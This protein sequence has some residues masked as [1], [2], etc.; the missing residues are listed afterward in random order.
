MESKQKA[1]N[2][3]DIRDP[4]DRRPRATV[5]I[6]DDEDAVRESTAAILRHVGLDVRE[7][8]D[9][10]AATWILASESI[11]VLLLDLHL[12]HQ[13]GTDVLEALEESSEVVIFSAFGDVEES[14]IRRHFG[15]AVFEFL[16]KP[17]PPDRLVEV[18]EAAVDHA[19]ADG[20]EPRV[21]PIA[22]RMALRLAMAGLSRISPDSEITSS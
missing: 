7:A 22:P 10:A 8:A 12:R 9:G 5:L 1:H 16:R 6:V 11:D 18:V 20:H 21:R 15:K 4:E 3:D 14:D 2:P 17:V 13:D 19:R